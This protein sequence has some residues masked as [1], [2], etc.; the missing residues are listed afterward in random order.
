MNKDKSTEAA[1]VADNGT[2]AKASKKKGNLISLLSVVFGVLI[3]ALIAYLQFK[4]D[5]ADN[6]S[7]YYDNQGNLIL[8]EFISTTVPMF[9]A[10]AL[11]TPMVTFAY[12][13]FKRMLKI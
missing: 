4:F 1:E 10:I 3:G 6:P 2:A 13:A 8:V 5:A 7:Q 9:L 11:G 12:I